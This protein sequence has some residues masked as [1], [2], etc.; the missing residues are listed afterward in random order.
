MLTMFLE[1][2]EFFRR[3]EKKSGMKFTASADCSEK[4]RAQSLL[5]EKST[6]GNDDA[7]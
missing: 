7:S 5:A 4:K 2:F 1:N 3:K 6:D